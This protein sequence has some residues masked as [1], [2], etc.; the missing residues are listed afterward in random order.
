MPAGARNTSDQVD[1]G[2]DDT[3][4][5]LVGLEI[6]GEVATRYHGK[7]RQGLVEV[8]E[9]KTKILLFGQDEPAWV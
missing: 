2:I 5:F 3:T 6:A 8:P 4:D 9:V 1:P 7:T